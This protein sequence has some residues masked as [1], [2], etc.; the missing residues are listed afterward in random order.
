MHRPTGPLTGLALLLAVVVGLTTAAP[1]LAAP[2]SE[3]DRVAWRIKI[4]L[5]YFSHTPG[6]GPDGTIYVPNLYGR[7]QAVAPDG[8]TRWTFPAGGG[9][10]P[11]SVAGDGTVIVAGGGPGA[12]GGTDGIFAINPN[13]TLK[14]GF[15]GTG[16]YLL[17]GPSIGPDGNVYAVTDSTGLGF[18]SLTPA[19]QLRFA[20]GQFTDHGA[21]GQS[22]AFGPDR[23][24]FGF[25]MQGLQP[26]T[27]F[28]Y[29]FGGTLR[30]T[31]GSADDPPNPDA[32]PNGNAVFRAFPSTVGKSL[33]S[34]SPAGQRVFSFYEF[35]GN[36]QSAP[37]VGP[38]NVTYSVRN[39]STLLALNP[40]GT[41]RWRYVDPGIM[42]EPVVDPTNHIV[43]TGGR[44]DY[45]QP[46]FFL[47]ASVAGQ[48]LWKVPLPTEPGYGDYGQLVPVS[49][50][51]FSPDGSVA[52]GIVDVAGDGNTP[53]PDLFAYLYAIRT[54]ASGSTTATTLAAPTNLGGTALAGG[55]IELR[56]TDN[57][58]GEAGTRIQRCSGRKCTNFSQVGWVGPN[59]TSYADTGLTAGTYY[60][61]RVR[62]ESATAASA[63]SNKVRVRAR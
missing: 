24:Y 50:P 54:G 25:D 2:P 51:V 11:I 48:A 19:G 62:A 4:P 26:S 29:D 23:V 59:A 8:T 35:P 63:W 16:D 52:Y 28:A 43:F 40:D 18:F 38:D 30:W 34:Y 32:G 22:I 14:W 31:T 61:Y 20:K 37:D 10:S 53:Y 44:V 12:V 39:L 13:G 9:G 58:T 57:S 5:D 60:R 55:R 46:G 36:T 27:F 17:A 15:T 41:V 21:L 49:R 7:T 3:P 42:F 56:W 1:A 6:I 47:G 33:F 45:G